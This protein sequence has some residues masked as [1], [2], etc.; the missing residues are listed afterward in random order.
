MSERDPRIT[1]REVINLLRHALMCS[2]HTDC[3]HCD[4]ARSI[5]EEMKDLPCFRES[6]ERRI[7]KAKEPW[8]EE[9]R[10]DGLANGDG[11]RAAVEARKSMVQD[12]RPISAS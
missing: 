7:P 12:L 3:E 11:N 2:D 10:S 8:C 6:Y 1:M 4:K 9:G 5:C